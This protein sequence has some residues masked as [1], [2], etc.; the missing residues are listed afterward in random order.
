MNKEII[1]RKGIK[2]LF[3]ALSVSGVGILASCGSNV[4]NNDSSIIESMNTSGDEI[5]TQDSSDALY[6]SEL[7]KLEVK[8][9]DNLKEK[10]N[11]KAGQDIADNVDAKYF[12]LKDGELKL[13]GDVTLKNSL[14]AEKLTLNFDAGENNDF[15]FLSTVSYDAKSN[16]SENYNLDQLSTLSDFVE[17]AAKIKTATLGGEVW[18]LDKLKNDELE[19][20]AR[21]ER[22]EIEENIE[23][24]LV[25]KLNTKFMENVVDKVDVKFFSFEQDEKYNTTFFANGY[26]KLADDETIHTVDL[27]LPLVGDD[28]LNVSPLYYSTIDESKDLADN[29]SKEELQ[30][31]NN[32]L[33]NDELTF[34]IAGL[35]GEKWD[36]DLRT[37]AQIETEL[38][39]R[40]ENSAR[41]CFKEKLNTEY[42]QG[43]DFK[44][45]SVEEWGYGHFNLLK[46]NG[47]TGNI[48]NSDKESFVVSIRVSE[49]N[50]NKLKNEIL[51]TEYDANLDLKDNYTKTQLNE[52][53]DI[54][55]D[56]SSIVKIYNVGGQDY[57]VK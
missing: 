8:I 45:F 13:N 16:L 4:P 57:N 38:E 10:I 28:F 14:N 25:N 52:I 39:T 47:I 11:N 2:V 24:K 12:T 56:T 34:S 9:E 6:E 55:D 53:L 36:L 29:Y 30:V 44:Y 46:I 17:S 37:S 41:K 48:Y 27:G 49:N 33:A 43:V 35:D 31:V 54:V 20:Q 22:A 21:A 18:D 26:I 40:F 15:S 50:Y 5:N 3:A 7:L 19:R 32:Y 42:V 1:S 51:T 23:Q